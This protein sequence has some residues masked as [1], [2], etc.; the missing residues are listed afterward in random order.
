MK[1]PIIVIGGGGHAKVL[2]DIL[3][4]QGEKI[5]GFVCANPENEPSEIFGCS[6]LGTD[7]IV[8]NMAPDKV[9]LV[10]GI[11]SVGDTTIR[12]KIYENY[13]NYGYTFTSVI[14]SSAV[15]S[16]R[17]ILG[18][19]VQVFAGAIIQAGAVLGDNTIINV[20]AS[21]DH[22]C[23]IGP[24]VHIAPGATLSGGVFVGEGTHVGTGASIIQGIKIGT[25]TTV[26][27]GAVVIK[28]VEDRWTV[29]G[30]PARRILS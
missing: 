9:R 5:L 3:I 6:C 17:A 11:G 18:T 24:H 22:D 28:N 2:I 25:L 16:S 30:V 10:N 13:A 12:R 23:V 27:A 21:I 4:E 26:G 29:V 15:I 1:M 14:S 19:G 8:R 20:K 7:E